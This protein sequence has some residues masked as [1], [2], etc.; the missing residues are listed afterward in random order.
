MRL[1]L[2]AG[3]IGFGIVVTVGY[4]FLSSRAITFWSGARNV[5]RW[6]QFFAYVHPSESEQPPDRR[7]AIVY[8]ILATAFELVVAYAAAHPSIATETGRVILAFQIGFAIVWC[9][10]FAR[11][12]IKK[13]E[14]MRR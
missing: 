9:V 8:A 2:V 3:V 5:P 1:D 4:M 14:T 11:L 7:S 13:A 6:A 12:P 10:F